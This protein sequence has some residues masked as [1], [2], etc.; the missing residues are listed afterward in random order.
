MKIE[1]VNK[2]LYT[3]YINKYYYQFRKETINECITKILLILKKIYNIEVYSEFIVKCYINNT[4]GII[5]EIER[6][7]DPFSLYTKKTNL[8]IYYYKDSVFLYEI[9]DY[10]VK[11]KLNNYKLYLYDNKYYIKLIDEDDLSII[12]FS[13]KILYGDTINKIINNS[14]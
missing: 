4:Y 1:C 7:Y 11:N 14:D 13:N 5:L 8:E 2:N 6:K 3:I 9:E 10:F 12:E